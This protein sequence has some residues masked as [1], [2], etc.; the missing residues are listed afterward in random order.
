MKILYQIPSPE[1]VYAGRFIYEGYKDAFTDLGFEFKPF[2]SNNNLKKTLE[3]YKPNIFISS[4]NNYYLKY[5]DL[6]LLKKYRKKGLVFFNQ[7]QPWKKQNNQFGGGDL[8]SQDYLV[9]LIKKGLAGDIFFHWFEQEDPFMDGFTKFTGYKFQT[10]LLAA[11]K[12]KYFYDYSNKYQSDI[13]YVGSLLPDKKIF[14]KKHVFP[15]M[16]KYKV[17]IYGSDWSLKDKLLGYF[18]KAGQYFNIGILKSVRGIKLSVENE[19][20]V[21]SSSLVSLNIHENHQ[22]EYGSDFNE[23][24]FKIIACGGFEICD[25]VKNLRK[26]FNKKELVIAKDTNDWFDK[27]DYYIKNPQKRLPIIEAGKKKVLRDH[28]YHNRVEQIINIYNN[29]KKNK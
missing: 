19:R 16:K 23:R 6:E 26:Y 12:K 4:L 8:Q 14:I 22:R 27:I 10:I 1:T 18:Q 21:Y 5:L 3:E 17:K 9:E 15:L 20:K 24:T 28:T 13:S 25:N 11:N 7:I 29:F 2:T